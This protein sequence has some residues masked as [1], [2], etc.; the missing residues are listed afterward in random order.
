MEQNQQL[1]AEEMAEFRAFQ[2]AKRKQEL[3]ARRKENR[4]A[5]AAIVDE[6]V[7]AAI[8]Q[9]QNLS[10]M[11]AQVK[12]TVFDS[13]RDVL[14]MKADVMSLTQQGQ[15]SHTFTTSD[16]TMRLTLGANTI[17]AY[18]DTV[19]DGIAMVREYIESLAKD[20]NSRALVNAVLRLLSRDQKGTLKASRVLQLRKM[21]E[22]TGNDRFLEG[23]RII[24]ESYQPA[25]TKQYIRA[26]VKNDI[27]GWTYIPLSVTDA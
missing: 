15:H 10:H 20:D 26:E 22:E 23:V 19:E 21:A 7:E 18:R 16:G 5:Y 11:I 25:E 8:V 3:A 14:A 12:Q 1:S 6:Q 13:F 27:G 2:E 9:L 24:E 4:E 17:D